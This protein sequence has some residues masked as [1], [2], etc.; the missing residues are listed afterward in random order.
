[1]GRHRGTGV[2]C[3]LVWPMSSKVATRDWTVFPYVDGEVA[4]WL[5]VTLNRTGELNW[6][7]WLRRCLEAPNTQVVSNGTHAK[8]GRESVAST[9]RWLLTSL[10]RRHKV[11]PEQALYLVR[12]RVVFLHYA[13]GSNV[14]VTFG[15]GKGGT[16]KRG[17]STCCNIREA[18][19]EAKEAGV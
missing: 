16:S 12:C 13:K 17:E 14:P 19:I 5:T 3:N 10:P 11:Y 15:T 18:V 2:L 4:R 8:P 9:H 1:M 6:E 7:A